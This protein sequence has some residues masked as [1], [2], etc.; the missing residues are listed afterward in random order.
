[1]RSPSNPLG[2]RDSECVRNGNLLAARTLLLLLVCAAKGV[3]F[4][5]EQPSSSIMER[6]PLFQRFLHL[7]PLKRMSIN[8]ADYGGPTLKPT[9]LYSSAFGNIFAFGS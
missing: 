8:M 1:M 5:L 3:W 2:R 9:L 4:V 6:L 7:K